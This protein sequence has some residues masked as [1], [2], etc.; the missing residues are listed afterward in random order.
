[1]VGGESGLLD[2]SHPAQVPTNCLRPQNLLRLWR[3]MRVTKN[4]NMCT[5][6]DHII[7]IVFT[8]DRIDCPLCKNQNLTSIW[9]IYITTPVFLHCD[10]RSTHCLRRW[11]AVNNFITNT[12]W[13]HDLWGGWFWKLSTNVWY[14]S[15][16]YLSEYNVFSDNCFGS[17]AV[18]TFGIGM[19]WFI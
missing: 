2:N 1:M 16:P 7:F 13:S 15:C 4:M 5:Y 9:Y 10:L 12:M 3:E 19:Q 14:Y 6:E 17:L 11:E 8:L 18:I